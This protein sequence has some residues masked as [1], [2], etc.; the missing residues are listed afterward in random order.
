MFVLYLLLYCGM[1][2]L[3]GFIDL[4]YLDKK[5]K[6]KSEDGKDR[7]GVLSNKMSPKERSKRHRDRKKIYYENLE[8]ENAKLIK[9]IA[10]LKEENRNLKADLEIAKVLIRNNQFSFEYYLTLVNYLD[11]NFIKGYVKRLL[12]VYPF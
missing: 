6:D 9:E 8:K 10:D 5:R 2:L 7:E 1:V 4:G 11:R 3:G 12:L